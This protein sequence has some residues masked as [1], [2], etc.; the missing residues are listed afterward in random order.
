MKEIDVYQTSLVGSGL[1]IGYMLD[2]LPKQNIEAL[3]MQAITI[4]NNQ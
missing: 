4:I 1:T 2:K 3:A